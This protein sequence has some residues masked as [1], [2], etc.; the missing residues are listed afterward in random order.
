VPPYM[1]GRKVR[2]RYSLLDTNRVGLIDANVEIPLRPVNT[3]ANAHR[4][5]SIAPP[6]APEQKPATGL[7][8]PELVLDNFLNP[9]GEL[10]DTQNPEGGDDE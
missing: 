3:I 6:V 2:L 8:A 10:D 9:A 7:N 4:S 1:R 5:R